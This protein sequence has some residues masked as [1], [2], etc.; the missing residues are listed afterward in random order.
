[1][2][3]AIAADGKDSEAMV[4]DRAGRAP[5]YLIYEDGELVETWKN[6]FAVGGG[7]AGWSVAYKLA[8][9]GVAR[10]VA[11]RLGGNFVKALDEKGVD[12]EEAPGEQ[13]KDVL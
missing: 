12:H 4:S 1:M 11:G 10:V 7:G 3:Q 6:P 8:E 9:K 2:K 13:V 5:Y